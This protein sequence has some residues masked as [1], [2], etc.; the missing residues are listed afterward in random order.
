[1]VA[2]VTVSCPEGCVELEFTGHHELE[3]DEE[4]VK[5]VGVADDGQ[6]AKCGADLE[7]S[8]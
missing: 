8:G 5:R 1:M 6:C 7:V 2:T 4:Y 3:D